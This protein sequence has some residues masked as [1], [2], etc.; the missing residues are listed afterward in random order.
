MAITIQKGQ[1]A[2]IDS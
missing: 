2:N 1:I